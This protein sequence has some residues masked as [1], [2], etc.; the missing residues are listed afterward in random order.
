M[1]NNEA[2]RLVEK[3]IGCDF[4]GKEIS[5][6]MRSHYLASQ[7]IARCSVSPNSISSLYVF[8]IFIFVCIFVE[9]KSPASCISFS[10]AAPFW[11]FVCNLSMLSHGK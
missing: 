11:P 9:Y 1:K 6:A 3:V 8:I 10:L 5:K 7:Y 2:S 4:S